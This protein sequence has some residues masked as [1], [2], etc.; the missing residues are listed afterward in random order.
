MTEQPNEAH[1]S[2]D[3]TPADRAHEAGIWAAENA[4]RRI[5]GKLIEI[6]DMI[7]AIPPFAEFTASQE[8]LIEEIETAILSWGRETRR[9]RI[10]REDRQRKARIM[11]DEAKGSK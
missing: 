5:R 11:L 7:D 3:E 10:E 1:P 8:E 6:G 2:L 4:F 9:L